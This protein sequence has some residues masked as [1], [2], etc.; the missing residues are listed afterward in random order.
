[1]YVLRTCGAGYTPS[2]VIDHTIGIQGHFLFQDHPEDLT[3]NHP[4]IRPPTAIIR[5]PDDENPFTDVPF[6][7]PYETEWLQD[8]DYAG[9]SYDQ[10]RIFR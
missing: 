5:K 9:F 6:W 2:I 10:L 1:M 7:G 3:F 4:H 8:Q